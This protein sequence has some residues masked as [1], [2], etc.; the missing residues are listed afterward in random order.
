MKVQ[1]FEKEFRSD[2]KEF[3]KKTGISIS[4]LGN[5]PTVNYSNTEKLTDYFDRGTGNLSFKVM[6]RIEKYINEFESND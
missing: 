3:L 4:K 2:V 6:E 5:N 1:D